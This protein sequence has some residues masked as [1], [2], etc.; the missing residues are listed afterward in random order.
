MTSFENALYVVYEDRRN[1]RLKHVGQK[2][3]GEWWATVWGVEDLY[4]SGIGTGEDAAEAIFDGVKQV[5]DCRIRSAVV[6]KDT[7]VVLYPEIQE[8]VQASLDEFGRS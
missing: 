6:D 4:L 8:R 7:K 2:A 3:N 5:K 1:L